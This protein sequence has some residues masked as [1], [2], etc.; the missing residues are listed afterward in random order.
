M[1]YKGRF[2]YVHFVGGRCYH[3]RRSVSHTSCGI[4]LFGPRREG[5]EVYRPHEA[6][7]ASFPYCVNCR[8]YVAF[9]RQARKLLR[10]VAD[11]KDQT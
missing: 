8:N 6:P 9:H 11:A 7:P 4:D 2:P 1:S 5:Q 3:T 10:E